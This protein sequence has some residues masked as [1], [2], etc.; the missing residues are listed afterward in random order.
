MLDDAV[1]IT[2][3]ANDRDSAAVARVRA[4]T[5]VRVA[6]LMAPGRFGNRVNVGGTETAVKLETTSSDPLELAK[7]I[8]FLL[9][10]GTSALS[11]E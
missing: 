8:A 5:R 2:D 6:Q 11:E 4:D 1:S 7:K 3:G 9:R 10:A